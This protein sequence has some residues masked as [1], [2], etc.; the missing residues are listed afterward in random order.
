MPWL[1]SGRIQNPTADQVLVDTS[2]LPTTHR[3][4][5]VI[6]ASTVATWFE[7]QH[8]NAANDANVHSQI[9]AVPA[10]GTNSV[11]ETPPNAYFFM[12]EGERLRIIQGAAV[13]AGWVSVSLF[14]TP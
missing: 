1:S 10:M 9:L 4:F 5:V 8:R 6:A 2:T 12:E 7:L 11:P 14:Y 13:T 3:G